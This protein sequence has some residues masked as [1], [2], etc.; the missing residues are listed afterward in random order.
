MPEVPDSSIDL[1]ANKKI[2]VTGAAGLLGG[3]LVKQ[4]LENG[5]RVTAIYHSTP[6]N[7]IHPN[8]T[9]QQCDILD[10]AGWK[11]NPGIRSI[12]LLNYSLAKDKTGC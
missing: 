11:N 12:I 2:L 4:L 1:D 9:A 6:V 5:Y 8:L 10:T 3:E 7:I